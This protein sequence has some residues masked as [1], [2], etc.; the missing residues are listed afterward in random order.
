MV[1]RMAPSLA[2]PH[3]AVLCR[4]GGGPMCGAPG[5][6]GPT[7]TCSFAQL[8]PV[9]F[10]EYSFLFLFL[11]LTLLAYFVLP[12][13]ARNGLLVVAS[14]AFYSVSSLF[15]APILLA[16]TV[17]DYVVGGRIAAS[18]H[19]RAR[20]ALLT[21]SI[22]S[23]LALLGFFKYA[24]FVTETLHGLLGLEAVPIIEVAL[25]VGISFYTFQSMSYSIDVYRGQAHRARSFVDFAAFVTLFPQLIAGPIVRYRE[26]E[27]QLRGRAHSLAAAYDGVALFTLGLAKKLLLADTAAT[28][29]DP[30][31]AAGSPS[32]AQAWVAVLAYGAQIYFDFSG[33]SDMARGLGRLFGFE[34]PVNF[35]SP[36][37]ARS[38]REF[39]RRWHMTLSTWLRD[40]VYIPLGGSRHGRARTFMALLATMLLGGLWHGA[41]WNFVIWG[42]LHG[43]YL[44]LERVLGR[45]VPAGWLPGWAR[46]GVVLGGVMVAWVFFRVDGLGPA[47]GWLGAMLGLGGGAGAASV[48]DLMLLG[49]LYG[50]ALVGPN[51]DQVRRGPTWGRVAV[52]GALFVGSLFVGYGRGISPFLYFRF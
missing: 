37:K 25:P 1:I 40:Y 6:R 3:P 5:L 35:D 36:Y 32:A 22:A 31:F 43:V 28:L 24:G 8:R 30:L 51:S 4:G 49:A 48:R 14:L 19:P 23:N 11:P 17:L 39:W 18:S 15:Y 27:G 47:V 10:H 29:A 44:G 41:S 33:Y 2:D 13:R 50:L 12:P 42:A 20:A 45:L 16:S 34:L 9:L 7:L 52:L 38:F 26:L 21:V 46:Q